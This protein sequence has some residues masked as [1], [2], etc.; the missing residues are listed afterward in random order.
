MSC[1][2]YLP[3]MEAGQVVEPRGR[4]EDYFFGLRLLELPFLRR[5]RHFAYLT[6]SNNNA[7]CS[8][9]TSNVVVKSSVLDRSLVQTRQTSVL[10]HVEAALHLRLSRPGS[11]RH[12]PPLKSEQST[13]LRSQHPHLSTA[14]MYF[15][16]LSAVAL[17]ASCASAYE[18]SSPF[19]F[20]STS[21]QVAL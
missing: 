2:L 21:K 3:L 16:A 11:G 13:F 9:T 10:Q 6:P 4:I 7:G 17:A 5:G 19:F 8:I 14:N 12:H 18:N 15:A 1:P 20:Y